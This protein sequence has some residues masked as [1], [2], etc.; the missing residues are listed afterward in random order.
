MGAKYDVQKLKDGNFINKLNKHFPTIEKS[1][2]SAL[3][4]LKNNARILS[5]RF[6][7]SDLAVIPIVDYIFRQPHQQI[8]ESVVHHLRQYLYMSFLLSFYSYGADGKIDVIH[9][10]L[11]EADGTFPIQSIGDFISER[12]KAP[13]VFSEGLLKDTAVVLNIIHGGV[14]EIPKKRGWSL[15]QDHIFPDSVL[16]GLGVPENLKDGIG[17]LRYLAKVRNILKSNHLPDKNLD[18]YGSDVAL[19]KD[20]YLKAIKGLSEETFALFAIARR[21]Y[22]SD[23]VRSFLGFSGDQ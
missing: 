1:L 10:K 2:F 17:N 16:S 7:R 14:Y 20:T 11:S 22:I 12:T 9:K 6:L 5:K 18:F 8:P 19:I 15:E 3:E 13:F 4:F 23:K 21:D